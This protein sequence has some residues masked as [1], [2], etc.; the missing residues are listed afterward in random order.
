M[1]KRDVMPKV[2]AVARPTSRL[3]AVNN[4]VSL[5]S[6]EQFCKILVTSFEI[7]LG[8]L[9]PKATLRAADRRKLHFA[10]VIAVIWKSLIWNFCEKV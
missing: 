6:L 4:E 7:L 8:A 1:A 2:Y 3:Q 10:S 9:M 5:L